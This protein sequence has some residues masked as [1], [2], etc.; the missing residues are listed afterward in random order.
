MMLPRAYQSYMLS[1]PQLDGSS[2]VPVYFVCGDKNV[3]KT[4]LSWDTPLRVAADIVVE[5]V[6]GSS[7]G[8]V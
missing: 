2:A 3:F 6:V 7:V 4:A 5:R 8:T 1:G